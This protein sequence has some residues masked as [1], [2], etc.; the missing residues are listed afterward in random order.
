MDHVKTLAGFAKAARS[1]AKAARS[2]DGRSDRRSAGG[3][4]LSA[5]SDGRSMLLLRLRDLAPSCPSRPFPLRGR[6][7]TPPH[8]WEADRRPLCA[9]TRPVA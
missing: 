9:R 3:L 4:C 6:C 8:G 7:A 2:Q 1:F 5:Q